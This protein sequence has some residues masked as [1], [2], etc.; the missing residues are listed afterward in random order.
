MRHA[1]NTT[2]VGISTAGLAAFLASGGGL[3]HPMIPLAMLVGGAAVTGSVSGV[4][5]TAA[6]GGKL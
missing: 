1:L 2:L 5:L 6:I 4:T 3:E